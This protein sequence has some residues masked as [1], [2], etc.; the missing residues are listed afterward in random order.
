MKSSA[1]PTSTAR[2]SAEAYAGFLKLW[3]T[4]V[5]DLPPAS[6]DVDAYLRHA[7][8]REPLSEATRHAVLR[9]EK[10]AA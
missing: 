3:L 7:N 4:P 6:P 1:R 8:A 5:S 2:M 10:H 9:P